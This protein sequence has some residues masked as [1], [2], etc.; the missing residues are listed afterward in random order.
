MVCSMEVLEHVDNPAAFIRSCCDLVK[1]GGHLF[2][3][4]IAR[5]PLAYLLTIFMA[6]KVM[7]TVTPGTHTYEKFVNSDELLDFFR[8]EMHWFQGNPGRLEAEVRGII[9]LPWAGKW[10][11][12]PRGQWGTTECNYMFWARKPKA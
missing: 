6:E 12:A 8:D 9:Y 5:T 1:P 7:R 3:S 10:E 4:T 2:L 11:L